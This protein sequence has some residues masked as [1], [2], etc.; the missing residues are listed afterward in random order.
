MD[1]ILVTG[2][3]G[4]IGSHFVK[5]LLDR[6][7]VAAV[8]VLDTLT[9]AGFKENLADVFIFSPKLNF[10]RGNILDQ[11]L[12]D[13]LVQRHDRNQP[14]ATRSPTRKPRSSAPSPSSS[15]RPAISCP[16]TSGKVTLGR[17]PLTKRASVWQTPHASTA[18]LTWPTPGRGTSFS[19]RC[20]VPLGSVVCA[21]R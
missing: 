10:E 14:T 8:T 1:K 11:D 12:V 17:P 7:D 2:G 21:T 5:R 13:E 9:Y 16:G 6:E 15:M 4:F 3:A 19:V 20:S 18:I